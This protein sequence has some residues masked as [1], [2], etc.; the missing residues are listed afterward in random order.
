[1]IQFIKGANLV[2]D[3]KTIETIYLGEAKKGKT[4]L[5]MGVDP[6]N[7]KFS[8]PL[9]LSERGHKYIAQLSKL[10]KDGAARLEFFQ[11]YLE[12][13]EEMLARDAY[14]EFAQAPYATVRALKGKMNHDKILAWIQDG[15]IPAT[16]RR[17]Y[18]TMLGICGG[19]GD[20]PMLE[21]L[22][23]SDDRKNKGG[24]DAL[25]ACYLTLRGAE[26]M[27]LVE[28]LYL[29]NQKAEYADTYAAIM[30]LR[31][32]GTEL[33]VVPKERILTGLHFMLDRP[34]LADLVIPDLA[35]WEDWS[36]M[37]RL[38]KLFKE[39]DEKTSWVRVPVVNYL[40]ACPLPEAKEY[41]KEL[42]KVD[43]AAVKRANTFFPSSP[44]GSAPAAPATN[45]NTQIV[46]A[47]VEAK[48]ELATAQNA[49]APPLAVGGDLAAARYKALRSQKL[50]SAATKPDD[51][52]EM[53]RPPNLWLSLGVPWLAG[54]ALMFVQWTIL[55]G[56]GGIF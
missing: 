31:F 48:K 8:T 18:L 41:I 19:A 39:A 38:V 10:P 21:G 47:P 29:K 24:L 15:N 4:F 7:V 40:R 11:N 25:I 55:R 20:I 16:R 53:V 50:A 26:G 6:P 33:N 17:L 45:T 32:H 27:P 3:K 42:E 5:I 49:A 30:A 36:V 43:P 28:D 54:V 51:A 56:G 35:R 52:S 2:K 34:Q 14:D 1:V 37:A 23:R 12:D 46:P 44:A 9:P 13:A 22:L